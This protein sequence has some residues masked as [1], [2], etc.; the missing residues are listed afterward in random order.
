MSLRYSPQTAKLLRTVRNAT[1][2][3]LLLEGATGTGLFTAAASLAGKD[4]FIIVRPTDAKGEDDQESGSIKIAQIRDLYEKTKGIASRQR[5]VIIDDADTM[6]SPAQNAFLKLLE[7][8]A[9]NTHFILTSHH[10]EKLLPTIISRVQRIR[11]TPISTEQTRQLIDDLGVKDDRKRSQLMY[12]AEGLPAEI[13]RLASNSKLFDTK[14]TFI[15]D[16]RTLLQ[17]KTLDKIKVI[18]SYHLKRSAALGL[19]EAAETIL[20]RSIH[21]NPSTDTVILAGAFA[22]VHERIA[23]NGNVRL[24]LLSLVV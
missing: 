24:Q 18:N 13:S 21:N 7:E 2:H 16:A 14:V 11:I 15:T 23:A 9:P 8:P 4:A 22:D 19:I 6:G 17:G 3:A 10:P 5:F 20:G 1:P 12:V